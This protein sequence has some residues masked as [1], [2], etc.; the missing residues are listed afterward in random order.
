M[1]TKHNAFTGD[2]SVFVVKESPRCAK[3]LICQGIAYNTSVRI[4]PYLLLLK[5][6]SSSPGCL[7][8]GL[9]VSRLCSLRVAIP[10]REGE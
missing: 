3:C 6:K 1:Y 7:W 5:F 9:R 4:V 8:Y 10:S 2:A